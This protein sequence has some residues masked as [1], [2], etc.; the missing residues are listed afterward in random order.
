VAGRTAVFEAK[1]QSAS[2]SIDKKNER[3]SNMI[4][5]SSEA[6]LARWGWESGQGLGRERNGIVDPLKTRLKRDGS[7]IGCKTYGDRTTNWWENVYNEAA[8][9]SSVADDVASGEKEASGKRKRKSK[10]PS[11]KKKQKEC[12]IK[13]QVEEDSEEEVEEELYLGR[14]VK[15]K[16]LLFVDQDEVVVDEH[17]KKSKSG[18]KR[19][20]KRSSKR[21]KRDKRSAESKPPKPTDDETMFK[22]CGGR[23]TRKYAAAGKLARLAEQDRLFA[24]KMARKDEERAKKRQRRS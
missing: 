20:K 17:K 16:I 22:A 18:E 19:K 5:S 9:S 3:R 6:I 10:K 2:I 23:T 15:A 4:S 8:S 7:G 21:K 24:E 13:I 1:E 11:S 14:F 12:V